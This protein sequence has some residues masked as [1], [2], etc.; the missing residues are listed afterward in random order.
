M[1]NFDKSLIIR[2]ICQT[3]HHQMLAVYSSRLAQKIIYVHQPCNH[4]CRQACSYSYTR[5][6][7]TT[8]SI[9]MPIIALPNLCQLCCMH[10][11]SYLPT[12]WQIGSYVYITELHGLG[13]AIGIVRI[14]KD[15][16]STQDLDY[17]N[18]IYLG[19]CG[20][21]L[22]ANNIINVSTHCVFRL[23]NH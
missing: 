8:L 10:L 5:N 23:S 22:H 6:T 4:I 2:Q 1:E 3:F 21:Q 18:K 11:A 17:S 14:Q 19:L 12:T 15:Y 16:R 9:A 20:T 7:C 13:K